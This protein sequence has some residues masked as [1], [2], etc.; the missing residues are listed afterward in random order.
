LPLTVYPLDC[1]FN[2][3][4]TFILQDAWVTA[5]Q[6]RPLSHRGLGSDLSC[7]THFSDLTGCSWATF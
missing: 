3:T 6:D 4:A 5:V 2:L 1:I 7:V